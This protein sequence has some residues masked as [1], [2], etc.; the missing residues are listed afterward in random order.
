MAKARIFVVEDEVIVAEMLKMN[1]ERS[2]YE[3]AGHEIYGE[4]VVEAVARSRPHLILMDI[5]LKGKMDGISAAIQVRERFDIPIIYLMPKRWSAPSKR[6]RSAILSS[7]SR[8]KRCA[9]PSKR[10]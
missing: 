2:G 3:I 1:L 6:H 10:R 9:R 4:A 7:P 8:W 5:R